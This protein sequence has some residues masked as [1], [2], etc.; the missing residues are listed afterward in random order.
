MVYASPGSY[1]RQLDSGEEKLLTNQLERYEG[2]T[3]SDKDAAN[4]AHVLMT[5]AERAAALLPT[6][7]TQSDDGGAPMVEIG[8]ENV[9]EK[10]PE[11]MVDA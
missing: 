10:G 7:S 3:M 1:D 8:A 2:R 11:V 9:E 6:D 4:V 5:V